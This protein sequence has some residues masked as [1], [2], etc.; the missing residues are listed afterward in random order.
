MEYD[1]K[2]KEQSYKVG[3]YFLDARDEVHRI[4][5][6]SDRG[7]ALLDVDDAELSTEYQETI[8]DLIKYSYLPNM[9]PLRQIQNAA[10]EVK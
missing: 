7:Y 1:I 3:D 8:E 4:I 9:K 5:Y 10:F 6:D 2:M